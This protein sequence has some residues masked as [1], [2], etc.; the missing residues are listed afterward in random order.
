M[1]IP[2]RVLILFVV[3]AL[4]TFAL[5]GTFALPG[6]FAAAQDLAPVEQTNAATRTKWMIVGRAVDATTGKPLPSF[7]VVPGTDSIDDETGKTVV[8]WRE[9]LKRDMKAGQLQWPR[10]SGFSVMRFRI[11]APGYR[12][13]VTQMMRRGGPHVRLRMKLR[14]E[15]TLT[16]SE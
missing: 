4:H 12:P 15:K 6:T 3:F 8:R 2:T 11:S 10:T 7:S 9:N 16:G 13:L 5:A 14:P 1:T